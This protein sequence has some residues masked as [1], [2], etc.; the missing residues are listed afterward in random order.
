MTVLPS[1]RV[2]LLFTD[3]EGSTRLVQ[4]LGKDYAANLRAH[5]ELIRERVE[6]AG[7]LVL[8]ARGDETSRVFED[9]D[10]ALGAAIE[11][12]KAIAAHPWPDGGVFRIRVG[13]H[14][15]DPALSGGSYYGVD[16]HRAARVTDTGHGGQVVVSGAAR[17]QSSPDFEFVDLGS[18]RL[19]GLNEPEQ[20]FQLVASGLEAEFPPLRIGDKLIRG[21]GAG[22]THA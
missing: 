4:A 17:E 15:G 20:V 1:G 14:T 9:V 8:E 13:V 16:V 11:A 6:A 5:Q 10:S 7:G 3:V 19:R 22:D 18:H 21:S 12:Q 2:T